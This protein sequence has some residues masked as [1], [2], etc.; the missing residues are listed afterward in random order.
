[1]AQ[2]AK[3]TPQKEFP[4]TSASL[5]QGQNNFNNKRISEENK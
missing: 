2:R 3:I 5:Y 1:M 4:A